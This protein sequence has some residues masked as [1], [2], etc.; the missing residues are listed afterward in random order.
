MSHAAIAVG[1]YDPWKLLECHFN[2]R[3]NVA[4]PQSHPRLCI[5]RGARQTAVYVCVCLWECHFV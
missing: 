1:L 3:E 4:V 2:I 5:T